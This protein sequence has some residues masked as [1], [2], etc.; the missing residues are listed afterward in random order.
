MILTISVK[1][2]LIVLMESL[3]LGPGPGGGGDN[4]PVIFIKLVFIDQLSD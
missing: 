4:H 1:K 3:K 2:F